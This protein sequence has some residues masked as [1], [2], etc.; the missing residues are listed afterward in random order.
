MTVVLLTY[1]HVE[2]IG[3]ALESV[4]E[5]KV[6]F[7][8]VV[9]ILDDCSSDGTSEICEKYAKKFPELFIHF[10]NEVNIGVLQ[11]LKRGLCRVES[12]YFAFLEGDDYYLDDRKLSIQYEVLEANSDCVICGHDVLVRKEGQ[13]DFCFPLA[14]GAVRFSKQDAIPIHP[15]ARVYRNVIQ[16]ESL[17]DFLV[18]DGYIYRLYLDHGYLYYISK[19]MS[20]Y[21]ET[22]SGFWSG[23]KRADKKLYTLWLRYSYARYTDFS[24][25]DYYS[26]KFTL[27]VLKK[28]FGAKLGWLFFYHLERIRIIVSQ[29]F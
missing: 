8:L 28:I 14:E 17:P 13:E 7:P 4:L 25:D 9:H 26:E 24:K 27:V 22:G 15:S 29:F 2:S 10:R 12:K 19:V 16:W 11:N 5:Q 1:N 21:N 23:R 18:L 6:S 20:V 3:R